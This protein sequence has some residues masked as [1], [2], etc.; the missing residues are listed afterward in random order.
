MI[1]KWK[2]SQLPSTV[3]RVKY[4]I[5]GLVSEI[6]ALGRSPSDYRLQSELRFSFTV[7]LGR[8]ARHRTKYSFLSFLSYKKPVRIASS[9]HG[10]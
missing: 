4:K 6:M 7:S 8:Q 2:A 9:L 5:P 10:L 1:F 3:V